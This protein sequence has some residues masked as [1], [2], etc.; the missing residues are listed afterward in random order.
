MSF[1][2]QTGGSIK[3]DRSQQLQSYG[4]LNNLFNFGLSSGTNATSSGS[5]ALGGAQNYYQNIL[6]GNRAQVNAAVA[7]GVNSTLSA[8]DATRR[9][10]ANMGTARGGGVASTNRTAGD[11]TVAQIQS[12]IFGAKPGAAAGLSST[13]SAEGSLGTSELGIANSAAGT[14]LGVSMQS[15]QD[16]LDRNANVTENIFDQIM[17]AFF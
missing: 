1:T 8:A 15:R 14:N 4:Q 13:G 6:S 7:P 5:G 11:T 12:Q 10:Q 9:Q 3:T 2:G 16:E 17:Q